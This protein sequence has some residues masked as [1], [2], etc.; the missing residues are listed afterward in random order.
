VLSTG[1]VGLSYKGLP[2]WQTAS[3]VGAL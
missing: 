2:A 3:P 1:A